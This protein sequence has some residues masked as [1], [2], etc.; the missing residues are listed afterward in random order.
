MNLCAEPWSQVLVIPEY[1]CELLLTGKYRSGGKSRKGIL[2]CTAIST[3][4]PAVEIA[5][6]DIY[7]SEERDAILNF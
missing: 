1:A 6:R 5:S 3:E 4:N 7:S 2:G